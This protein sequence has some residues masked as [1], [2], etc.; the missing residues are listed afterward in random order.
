MAGQE[1]AVE[2]ELI[3]GHGVPVP[4][5]AEEEEAGVAEG[6]PGEVTPRGGVRTPRRKSM[7]RTDPGIGLAQGIWPMAILTKA[8]DCTTVRTEGQAFSKRIRK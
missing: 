2:A 3:G 1:D 5:G 6:E 4:S 7:S 8:A